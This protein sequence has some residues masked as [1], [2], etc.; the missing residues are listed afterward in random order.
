VANPAAEYVP[1]PLF[2][3]LLFDEV[4][5]NKFFHQ[6]ALARAISLTTEFKW[7]N[8][9]STTLNVLYGLKNVL[10]LG[11]AAG[12]GYVET[13]GAS[14][15]DLRAITEKQLPGLRKT[16]AEKAK[17]GPEQL[18]PW[19]EKLEKERQAHLTDMRKLQLEARKTNE[20][21]DR[22]VNEAI[23]YIA[24]VK[25]A[26]ELALATLGMAPFGGVAGVF[27]R[28]GVGLGYP[29]F[30]H[31][32]SI[33]E[34]KKASVIGTMCTTVATGV[35]AAGDNA[36]SFVGEGEGPIMKAVEAGTVNKS[37]DEIAKIKALKKKHGNL[38][39]A[40][41]AK[42]RAE[43]AKVK[44]GKMN[45]SV[46]GTIA[47]GVSVYFYYKSCQDSATSYFEALE[48]M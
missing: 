7:V 22:L 6:L 29:I 16:W 9:G 3:G 5:L 34:G 25:F 11:N 45:M 15:A 32:L 13:R 48:G 2:P 20:E 43:K 39:K 4:A 28:L 42:L 19:M 47:S 17:Q 1:A 30:L 27:L 8:A 46:L 44:V 37:K 26:S 10:T 33:G 23:F 24:S 18:I 35:K 40:N 41:Q 21:V 31:L 38:S 12:P 14:G 36:S